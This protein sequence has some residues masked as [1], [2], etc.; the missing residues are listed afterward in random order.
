VLDLLF[1]LLCACLFI[2]PDLSSSC[3]FCFWFGSDLALAVLVLAGESPGAA[4]VSFSCLAFAREP[5]PSFV[6]HESSVLAH[7]QAPVELITGDLSRIHVFLSVGFAATG[8]AQHGQACAFSRSFLFGL[9]ICNRLRCSGPLPAP[10]QYISW[11]GRFYQ[12]EEPRF[13]VAA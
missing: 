4:R 3:Q 13:F 1:I 5:A 12:Q 11:S 8:V 2:A 6:P 9:L 10:N 7:E